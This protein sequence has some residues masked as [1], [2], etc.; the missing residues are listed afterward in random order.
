MTSSRMYLRIKKKIDFLGIRLKAKSYIFL[1]FVSCILLFIFLLLTNKLGYLIAPV[2]TIFYYYA[3]E[4][5]TLDMQIQRRVK[6]LED[7]ALLYFPVFLLVFSGDKNVKSAI[8]KSCKIV[9]NDLTVE[10]EKAVDLMELGRSVDEG[11]STLS[12]HIPSVFVNNII[13]DIMEANRLGNNIQ[14]S[15]NLQLDLIKAKRNR[16][17]ISELKAIPLRLTLLSVFFVLVVLVLLSLF[18]FF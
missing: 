17:L 14:E 5:V 7:D 9:K 11:L 18:K 16:E 12:S 8:I 3:I 1:R 13:V 4:I 10:F 6:K 15:I 2:F